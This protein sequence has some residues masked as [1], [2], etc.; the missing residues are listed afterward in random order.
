MANAQ[1]LPCKVRLQLLTIAGTTDVCMDLHD[2][3]NTVGVSRIRGRTVLCDKTGK[4]RFKV[5]IQ[6]WALDPEFPDAAVNPSTGTGVARPAAGP[7]PASSRESRRSRSGSP[8]RSGSG[9]GAA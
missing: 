2:F 9:A 3:L 1:R 6:T 8:A 4:F 7:E 5:G